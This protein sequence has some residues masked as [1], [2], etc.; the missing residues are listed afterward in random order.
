MTTSSLL[1]QLACRS[2][3]VAVEVR[4]TFRGTPHIQGYMY[5]SHAEALKQ[6]SK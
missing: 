3:M 5:M 6:C 1:L 2:H 4:E